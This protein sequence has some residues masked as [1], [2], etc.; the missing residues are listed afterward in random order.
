[1]LGVFSK[2]RYQTLLMGLGKALPEVVHKGNTCRM[3]VPGIELAA[4]EAL[5][6][7]RDVIILCGHQEQR[8]TYF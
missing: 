6:T 8:L 1:M 7:E 4:N 3:E 5:R 2:F